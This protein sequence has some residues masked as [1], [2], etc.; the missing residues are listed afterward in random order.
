MHTASGEKV[1]VEGIG[2]KTIISHLDEQIDL[3]DVV[4]CE[5]L[6]LNILPLAMFDRMGYRMEIFQGQIQFQLNGKLMMVAEL[7]SDD[8]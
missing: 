6:T 3:K 7:Q 8:L 5:R 1:Q 4:V 2:D